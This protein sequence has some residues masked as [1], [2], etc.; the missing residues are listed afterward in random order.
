LPQIKICGKLFLL[1]VVRYAADFAVFR[2]FMPNAKTLG[3]GG[4]SARVNAVL[5]ET[6]CYAG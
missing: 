5:K 2:Q 4:H 1:Y 6:I 3:E